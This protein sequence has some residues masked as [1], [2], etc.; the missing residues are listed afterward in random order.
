VRFSAEKL[1]FLLRGAANMQTMWSSKN[2]CQEG[3]NF[4]GTSQKGSKQ[5]LGSQKYIFAKFCQIHTK[6]RLL[7]RIIWQKIFLEVGNTAVEMTRDL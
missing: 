3:Q 7:F 4:S 5:L 2:S 6:K 1:F